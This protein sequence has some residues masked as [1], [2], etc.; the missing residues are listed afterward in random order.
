[1][2][3]SINLRAVGL[4]LL[5]GLSCHIAPVLARH[6]E[7]D[8]LTNRIPEPAPYVVSETTANTNLG[9]PA[10]DFPP[11]PYENLWTSL[12][13]AGSC[14]GC[15]TGLYD[16]WNGAMMSNAWRDPGWRGAFLLVARLTSTDGCRDVK[17]AITAFGGRAP[18]GSQAYDCTTDPV[19]GKRHSINPFANANDTSTF[20]VV[21]GT[22]TA[23]PGVTAATYSGSGSL[24]DDFCSRCHMPTNYVD[25]TINVSR[26]LP[27]GQE[28]GHISPTYDPTSVNAVAPITT[29]D[30]FT[31]GLVRESFAARLDGN[32]AVNSN[33]G[34]IGIVCEVCHTNVESRFT[35]YHN[36]AK[37]GTEYFPATRNAP[38]WDGAVQGLTANQ[39]A[40]ATMSNPNSSVRARRR[41]EQS[42]ATER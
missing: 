18:D 6:G 27:S 39:Q 38:R 16:Q 13:D 12:D 9:L 14:S 26:D 42:S 33:S 37:S 41:M 24:M 22:A 3:I 21:P 25:A 29:R 30:P 31:G 32:R 1:M 34:K 7:G 36:Y 28:H 5:L 23:F 11:P 40:G 2:T 10:G 4:V 15:H 35:P 20:N 17:D 8:I 19:T